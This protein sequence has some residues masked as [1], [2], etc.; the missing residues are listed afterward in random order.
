MVV[1]LRFSGVFAQLDTL[2]DVYRRR[3]K[4]AYEQ[5]ALD[6]TVHYITSN[7][8]YKQVISFLMAFVSSFK[9]N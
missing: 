8:V 5:K 4:S 2:G 7:C 9:P 3:M 1:L 6:A